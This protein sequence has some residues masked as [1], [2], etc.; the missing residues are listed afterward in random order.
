M[1]ITY[2]ARDIV[3]FIYRLRRLA[4]ELAAR[5]AVALLVR[6][7]SHVLP[8]EL[9]ELVFGPGA[10]QSQTQIHVGEQRRECTPG[11]QRVLRSLLMYRRKSKLVS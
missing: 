3:V 11:L 4:G 8:H 7:F 6:K 1:I 2:D 10:E 5:V 9:L